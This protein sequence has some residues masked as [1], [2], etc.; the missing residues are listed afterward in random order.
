MRLDAGAQGEVQA[1]GEGMQ[2]T[3]GLQ[4]QRSMHNG[5]V[6]GSGSGW[7]GSRVEQKMCGTLSR[8]H[9]PSLVDVQ[10]RNASL[11]QLYQGSHAT[12]SQPD[13][14]PAAQQGK[15]S[16]VIDMP[17]EDHESSSFPRQCSA[18]VVCCDAPTCRG[19]ANLQQETAPSGKADVQDPRLMEMGGTDNQTEQKKSSVVGSR[20]A[21]HSRKG[22]PSLNGDGLFKQDCMLT[23]SSFACECDPETAPDKLA[24][25]YT[26][27]QEID[28]R[29]SGI[30]IG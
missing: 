19:K 13:P 23:P 10:G 15:D 18:P 1:E 6:H 17:A 11:E 16:H 22:S 24:D 29:F 5:A 28:L 21:H 7:S 20:Q 9:T 26:G 25:I 14:Q 2:T 3:A 4:D 8:V 12:A 30:S 27:Q